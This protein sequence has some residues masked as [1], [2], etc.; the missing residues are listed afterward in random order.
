MIA[1]VKW[2]PYQIVG[3]YE[4]VKGMKA[5]EGHDFVI[6][7]TGSSYI[8]E[9]DKDTWKKV[10]GLWVQGKYKEIFIMHNE[11]KWTNYYYCCESYEKIV[12]TNIQ[13]GLN[14]GY[15]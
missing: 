6:G 5:P 2:E 14:K 13:Y 1:L 11:G 12:D 10:Y 3:I 8:W 7:L 15:V 4:S 9:L